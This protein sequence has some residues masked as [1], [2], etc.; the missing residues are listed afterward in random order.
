MD[1]KEHNEIIAENIISNLRQRQI[2]QRDFAKAIGI[3]PST[4]TDYLKL[5]TLPSHGVVQKMAD[6][7]G[8]EKS[9][10]DTYY[11]PENRD[12]EQLIE[13]ADSFEDYKLDR[14]TRLK[15]KDLIHDYLRS[16]Q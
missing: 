5:R 4:L 6:F 1:R 12:L 9:D 16:E 3:A 15:L 2:T 7:F 8:I 14:V 13:D 10:L 11:K